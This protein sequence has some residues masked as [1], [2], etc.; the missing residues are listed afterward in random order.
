MRFL[1]SHIKWSVV[2][3]GDT[4]NNYIFYKNL[5]F[6]VCILAGLQDYK[7]GKDYCTLHLAQLTKWNWQLFL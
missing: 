5:K 1:L 2:C 3:Y 4:A 6:V 7:V